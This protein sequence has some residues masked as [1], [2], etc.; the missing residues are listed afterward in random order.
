MPATTESVAVRALASLAVLAG[1][2]LL[3]GGC[4]AEAEEADAPAASE[5]AI[6]GGQAERG[7][8]AVG[9]LRFKSG[10]F[11][12]GSLISPTLVL[13]AAHV[14][15]GNPTVFHYG[16]P[17]AGKAPTFDNLRAVPVAQITIHPCYD[18]PKAAGCPGDVIDIALVRLAEPI[19]DVAPLAVVD[20]PLL[21]PWDF[22]SPWLGESCTAVGFGAHLGEDDKATFGMRRSATSRVSQIGPTELVT[23]RGTGI[24]T[25]GDSGGPLVCSG[26]IIGTVRGSAGG[27]IPKDA[28]PYERI[29]EGY[30]R[31]DLWRTW[32]ASEGTRR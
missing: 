18:T 5:D 4:A 7:W 25:S 27:A 16:T 10:N 11:G 2:S 6:L 13:T 23:V 1:L 15:K 3:A 24:A 21:A 32:I 14:A 20:A 22:V 31:S 17:A 19:R 26:R 30:E 8:P 12:T 29:K 9:M 28:S